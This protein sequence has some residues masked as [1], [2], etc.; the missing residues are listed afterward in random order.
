MSEGSVAPLAPPTLPQA[1]TGLRTPCPHRPGE[2]WR[3]RR[4]CAT[5]DHLEWW[6]LPVSVLEWRPQPL[7]LHWPGVP[8]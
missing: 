8:S 4:L 2:A 3:A 5:G 6:L 1:Q 7:F